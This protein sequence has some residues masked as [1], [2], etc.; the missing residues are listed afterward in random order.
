MPELQSWHQA[1]ASGL[2]DEDPAAPAAL[3]DGTP[4][5][6]AAGWMVYRN[7]VAHSLT[8]V[9][10]DTFPTVEALTGPDFFRQASR[11]YQEQV[12]PASA[13]VWQYGRGFADFL[14]HSP[15]TGSLP[16]LGDVARL[17]FSRW[18]SYHGPGEDAVTPEHLQ[19]IPP[20]DFSEARFKLKASLR[21]ARSAYPA[22]SIWLAHQEDEPD[23]SAI[24]LDVGEWGM[25][26][27][28]DGHV[29]TRKIEP[30]L[31]QF[32]VAL[33]EGEVLASATQQ[34]MDVSERDE[35]S[36]EAA[37]ALLLAS[38]LITDVFEK[39]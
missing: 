7:N 4:D 29:Y 22:V 11:A 21:L 16:W 25:T 35:F 8:E 5:R 34:A 26:Y 19:S 31:A 3:F 12:L 24:N 38:E 15:E 28:Q 33:Q 13:M 32:L 30:S 6:V 1:F 36:L 39:E 20:E 2:T 18:Q 23:F 27:R 14:D 37:L 10:R 17:E 9:L